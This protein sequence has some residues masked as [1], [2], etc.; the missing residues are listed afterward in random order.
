MSLSAEEIAK[1]MQG[2]NLQGAQV[3]IG[4]QNV[5]YSGNIINHAPAADAD[6]HVKDALQKLMQQKRDDGQPVFQ[7]QGQWYAVYRILVDCY[8]W[9]DNM[10]A[11]CRR[12]QDM[13]IEGVPCKEDSLKNINGQP[14]FFKPFDQWQPQGNQVQFDRLY[15]AAQTFKDFMD[16]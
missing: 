2:V 12:I 11:F 5:T 7:K 15:L 8:Q 4:A 10:A 9:P 1:I 16:E 13:H 14:P 3:N 6:A